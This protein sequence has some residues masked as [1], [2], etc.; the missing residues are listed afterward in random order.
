MRVAATADLHFTAQ[1]YPQ[2]HEQLGRVPCLGLA[3]RARGQHEVREPYV[4]GGG[5]CEKRSPA[6]DFD[7]IRVGAQAQD[8]KV[9]RDRETQHETPRCCQAKGRKTGLTGRPPIQG[10]GSPSS[11]ARR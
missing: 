2:F 9:L 6:T 1:R 8:V 5:E 4:V 10:P 11:S 7:V 3:V